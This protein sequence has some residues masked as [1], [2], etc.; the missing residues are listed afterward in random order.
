MVFGDTHR[1]IHP[2]DATKQNKGLIHDRV[3][4]FRNTS[5]LCDILATNKRTYDEAIVIWYRTVNF[6]MDL[7]LTRIG[8]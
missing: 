3:E 1:A 4:A 8:I 7:F 2:T 5:S 6:H